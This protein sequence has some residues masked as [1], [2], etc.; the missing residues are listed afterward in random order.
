MN[1]IRA[2][3][4]GLIALGIAHTAAAQQQTTIDVKRLP[5]DLTRVTTQLRQSSATQ[6]RN[7][8]HIRYTVDVYGQA[9]RIELFTEKDN[10]L[11]GPVPFGA[12][13]HREMLDNM[14]PFEYRAQPADLSALLRWLTDKT[15]RK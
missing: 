3:F 10:L 13:T 4:I 11:N 6:S 1:L 2:S 5:V 8:L 7:G 12:P 9:P 14:T 15:N